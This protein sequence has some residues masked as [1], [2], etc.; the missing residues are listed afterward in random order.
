MIAARFAR[1][2]RLGAVAARLQQPEVS[3]IECGSGD[4]A[5]GL[6]SEFAAVLGLLDHYERWQRL[7]AGVRVR[8]AGGLYLDPPFGDNWWE[9]YFEPVDI[10]TRDGVP[11]V[12]DRHY[13]DLC[14]NRVERTMSRDRG[15]ALVERYIALKPDVRLI[16]DRYIADHWL[17]AYVIGVHYRGTDK[18]IDAPRVPYEQVESVVRDAM[19][20]SPMEECKIFLA[21]DEQTFVHHMRDRFPNQLLFRD[22]F[23]S[24]DGRPTDVV[25]ADGNRQKGLDAVVDCLLLSKTHFL[26]RTAS[27]LS[28]CSTLFNRRLP[29]VLINPER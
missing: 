10:V 21:S 8:F 19:R 3:V 14:A 17:S 27:N 29:N 1:A 22:M 25:N 12:V 23:R 11:R 6:F 24:T 26:V 5:S 16:V 9:Y 15:A 2:S 7:Y 4:T 13:H 28:L 20:A 18:A